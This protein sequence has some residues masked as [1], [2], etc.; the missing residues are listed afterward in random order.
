PYLVRVQVMRIGHMGMNVANGF[1]AMF[2]AMFS[3]WFA[4]MAVQMVAIVVRVGMFM[5]DRFMNM[6]MAMRL[7]TVSSRDGVLGGFGQEGCGTIK[8]LPQGL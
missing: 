1:M 2:V 3:N 8:N 5:F 4:F 7:S 6:L